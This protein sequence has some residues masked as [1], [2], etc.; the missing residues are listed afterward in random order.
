YQPATLIASTTNTMLESGTRSYTANQ[1]SEGIDFY[2]SY[3]ELQVEQDFATV[4]VYSLNRYLDATLK[5]VEELI[6]FPVFP[7]DEFRIH[8]SNKKQKHA[9]NS[10]KVSVLARRKFTELLFG[11]DHPYGRDVKDKDFDIVNIGE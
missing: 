3:L 11:A 5:F 8:I 4:T 9:I 1:L 6:K 10:Q 7:E 2:G